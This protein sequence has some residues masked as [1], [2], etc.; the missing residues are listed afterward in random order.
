MDTE[1]R[2]SETVLERD[3][4]RLRP[5][6]TS[7]LTTRLIVQF[8]SDR[9]GDEGVE[10]LLRMC[11]LHGRRDE[12]EDENAWF[13][14]R[15]K[16]RLLEAARLVLDDSAAPRK[17]GASAVGLNVG[18]AMK[19]ALKAFGSPSVVYTNV[20]KVGSK[21]TTTHR[22]KVL[23]LEEGR[24]RLVFEETGGGHGYDAANCE[25]NVGLL[26]SAPELFGL[27]AASV[28]HPVC[29]LRGAERCEYEVTWASV[30]RKIGAGVAAGTAVGA[31]TAVVNR[32][33]RG[34]RAMFTLALGAPALGAAAQSARTR[35]RVARARRREMQDRLDA[36]EHQTRQLQASMRDL[37][38]QLDLD[39]VLEKITEHAHS[40]V[41]GKQY[42]LV[43][44]TG[45][46]EFACGRSGGI[47]DDVAAV[48]EGWVALALA[49]ANDKPC[50]IED[51]ATE[52]ALASLAEARE[53]VVRSLAVAPLIFKGQR[54]GAL[55]ALS[56]QVEGFFPRDVDMLEVY[57]AQAAAAIAN[58]RRYEVA[59]TQASRDPLTGLLNHREFHEKLA[60]EIERSRRY[61]VRCSL[62]L[63]DLDGFKGVNDTAGHRAGDRLLQDVALDVERSIRASD[64]AFRIGGDEFAVFLPETQGEEARTLAERIRAAV[65]AR[66]ERVGISCG[67]ATWPQDGVDKE[68][69]L[70]S[71]DLALYAAKE[72]VAGS[73][74]RR[75]GRAGERGGV[76]QASG[77]E[78][79]A[80]RADD[81]RR[82][83]RQMALMGRIELRLR[84]AR[85][86]ED[87]CRA[88]VEELD[89]E[90]GL[91]LTLVMRVSADG[92]EL[93][94]VAG[95]GLVT[96]RLR[97]RGIVEW[98]QPIARG[99]MGRVARTGVA[100]CLA[101]A[102]RDPDFIQTELNR[103]CAALVAVPI[104]VGGTV[105]GVLELEDGGVGTFDC[106]DQAALE[107]LAGWMASAM[108][109]GTLQDELDRAAEGT[110]EAL[111]AALEARDAAAAGEATR[112]AGVA[113]AAGKHLG[114][115]GEGLRRLRRAALLQ[116]VGNLAVPQD[117]VA[118]AG[119]LTADEAGVIERHATAGAEILARAPSLAD[120]A[121]VVH[122]SHERWDGQ[123]YPDGLR[124][125]EIPL[126]A[127]IVSVASAYTAIT[128]ERPYRPAVDP[129]A[130]IREL[131]SAAGTQFDPDVVEAI[132]AGLDVADAHGGL[133]PPR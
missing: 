124:G 21:L 65:S 42:A 84:D 127:R 110:V 74:G 86:P 8:V 88:A 66:D 67:I 77:A 28:R 108:Q 103:E 101:D 49:S 51:L 130:A 119:P 75:R 80:L 5:R 35:A 117:V 45:G 4:G 69:L 7:G 123:G 81:L 71:A 128:S 90:F 113:V 116:D 118:K 11:G 24:A 12:L 1:A 94:E 63:A 126:P 68:Q 61:G 133:T 44:N 96:D 70:R 85:E 53:Q 91:A 97:E 112:I 19:L 25:F 122:H 125:E 41:G 3:V 50:V 47:A 38:S 79:G 23:L 52:P 59:Q 46:G 76:E 20:A 114:L 115:D 2:D 34:P 64:L 92:R 54:L 106:D 33:A 37:V 102:R 95:R 100:E 109:S 58:A 10:R 111:L 82:R 73:G 32:V 29:A 57:A 131:R 15:D 129:E 31:V 17:I 78:R 62:I 105:W 98:R 36:Y 83:S 30:P 27:P 43:L 55:V 13:S 22:W 40:A 132:I 6:E 89:A 72:Q 99:V 93:V 104:P 9:A 56:D 121:P 26:R 18:E 60:Q 120:L 39:E 87:I 16:I 107:R 48:L 14:Y